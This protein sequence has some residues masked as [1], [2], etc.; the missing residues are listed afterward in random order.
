MIK[1]LKKKKYTFTTIQLSS[2]NNVYLARRNHDRR[3]REI[4]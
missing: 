3:Y 4:L 1:N 2:Q